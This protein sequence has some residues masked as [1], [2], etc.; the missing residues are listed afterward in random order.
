MGALVS[1]LRGI[2]QLCMAVVAANTANGAKIL[3]T[4]RPEKLGMPFA[5]GTE[6]HWTLEEDWWL[7]VPT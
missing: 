1:T 7:C 2:A 5:K 4:L 3:G 6:H